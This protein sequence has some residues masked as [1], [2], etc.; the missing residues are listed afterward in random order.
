MNEINDISYVEYIAIEDPSDSDSIILFGM[1]TTWMGQN[2]S[3]ME[4]IKKAEMT[5]MKML[6]AQ[7]LIAREI[8]NTVERLAH[9]DI[10]NYA[11]PLSAFKAEAHEKDDPT[12]VT[13]V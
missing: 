4:V 1:Y 10:R 5:G 9:E 6:Q 11:V 12:T 13:R 7:T 3:G 2:F 8:Q